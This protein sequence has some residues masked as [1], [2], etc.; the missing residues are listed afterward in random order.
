MA[1]K[2]MKKNELKF[3]DFEPVCERQGLH[4]KYI[5]TVNLPGFRKEDF[6][7]E[8]D[9]ALRV[10]IK[11][12]KQFGDNKCKRFN[13]DIYLPSDIDIE[14]ITGKF[15]GEVLTLTFPK[16]S[17]KAEPTDE[18]KARDEEVK[19]KEAETDKKVEFHDEPTTNGEKKEELAKA[20]EG[21]SMPGIKEAA[22]RINDAI[23]K[24]KQSNSSGENKEKTMKN[25][26]KKN[27]VTWKEKI[28]QEARGWSEYA[29]LD[30]MSD[31]INRNRKEIAIAVAAFS[32]GILVSWKLSSR[33]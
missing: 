11:G 8:I 25:N 6:R 5:V 29:S 30:S 20:K 10:Q 12:Q 4:D 22:S 14:N 19:P 7:V 32:I 2:Q 16:R 15:E 27:I 1:T 21:T 9:V 18:E 31:T 23:N 26:E 3:E 28:S 33:K 24:W 13:K 17:E